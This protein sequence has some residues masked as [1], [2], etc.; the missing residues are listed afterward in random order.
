MAYE[1]WSAEEDKK[2]FREF[3]KTPL[4]CNASRTLTRLETDADGLTPAEVWTEVLELIGELRTLDAEYRDIMVSEFYT[5]TR[6]KVREIERDGRKVFRKDEDVER[7]VTCIFYCLALCLEATTKD[8][9]HN[10][11]NHLLDALVEEMIRLDHPI[12]EKLHRGIKEDGDRLELRAGRE[13][14]EEKDPLKVEDEWAPQLERV[15]KHY[16]NKMWS[17]VESSHRDAFNRLWDILLTDPAVSQ[18]M[19]KPIP[20][21]GDEQKELGIS[22]NA[23]ALFNIYGMLY[24][25]GFFVAG[26]R[27]ETP[28]AA[29]VTQHYDRDTNNLKGAKYEYFKSEMNGIKEQFRGMDSDTERHVIDLITTLTRK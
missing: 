3:M 8:Q 14:I 11:H 5:I 16:A 17:Y 6:R 4:F 27:G 29:K 20:V 1:S 19:K 22:Y 15:F 13:L 10:P 12:L 28:L 23:K 7:T 24:R 18:V 21:A 25:R 2:K 26:I 9:A